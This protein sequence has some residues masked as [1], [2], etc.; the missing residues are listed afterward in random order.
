MNVRRITMIL[1]SFLVMP[2]AA[3]TGGEEAP[4]YVIERDTLQTRNF[5]PIINHAIYLVNR[6]ERTI[7]LDLSSPIPAGRYRPAQFSPVFHEESSLSEPLVAPIRLAPP[8]TT[9]L[10]KPDIETAGD[11]AT[12]TWKGVSI[13]PGEA[14]LAQ[15]DNYYGEPSVFWAEDGLN[16]AGLKVHT[17]Y[18]ATSTPDGITLSFSYDIENA[19]AAAVED[20]TFEAFIPLASVDEHPPL[21]TLTEIAVSPNITPTPVTRTDD[22]DR[23]LTGVAATLR[24]QHLPVDGTVH[25]FLRLTGL[26]TDATGE[27]W[28]VITI[29]G[30]HIRDPLWPP[31]VID[32]T[33]PAEIERFSYVSYNLVMRDS[34]MLKAGVEEVRV[35]PAK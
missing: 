1:A 22:L 19:T 30:R 23:T 13:M 25:F 8:K 33:K 32:L 24:L 28:P 29:R 14:M 9:G 17:D 4:L 5:T 34:R 3:W 35:T 16:L 15:Y 6:S 10:A 12:L 21:L 27:I 20:L 18:A 11:K 7:N 26:R 31:A 2:V